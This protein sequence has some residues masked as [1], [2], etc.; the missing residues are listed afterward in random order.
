[1]DEILEVFGDGTN[2]DWAFDDENLA[3]EYESLPKLETLYPDVST[4]A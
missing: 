4:W 2:Y 3:E 1:M